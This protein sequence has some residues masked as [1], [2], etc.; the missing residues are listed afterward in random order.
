MPAAKESP[1]DLAEEL[2][3]SQEERADLD[4]F[5]VENRGRYASTDDEVEFLRS[6]SADRAK[7]EQRAD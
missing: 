7:R 3:L 2:S 1:S 4:A 6:V 5:V